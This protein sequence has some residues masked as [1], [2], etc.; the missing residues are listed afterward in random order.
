MKYKNLLFDVDET[1]LDFS[2]AS[3]E[4]F[5][6]LLTT[7]GI[8]YTAGLYE[9]Y[10]S[11][12]KPLWNKLEK[13]EATLEEILTLRFKDF[14]SLIERQDINYIEAEKIYQDSLGD[15]A[16]LLDGVIQTLDL[17]K[18]KYNLYIITN[19]VARTQHKRLNKLNLK[20][21]FSH[22][23]ISEEIGFRK[24]DIN[25]MNYVMKEINNY[26]KEDYLII[27]DSMSSDMGLA[28]NSGVDAVLISKKNINT[29]TNSSIKYKF[30]S[31]SNLIDIL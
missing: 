14:F 4:A 3:L 26:N 22:I 8:D 31:V 18:E 12:N 30:S 6:K 27:G 19:G 13:G 16:Y 23:F 10:E 2:R 21:Y 29:A 1:L 11:V 28:K 24:P 25:F 9:T 17:L 5:K 7:Y 15:G 20:E